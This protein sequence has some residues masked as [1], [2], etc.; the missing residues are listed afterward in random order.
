M[1]PP[2]LRT[3]RLLLREFRP[4]DVEPHAA[5]SRDAAAQRFLGGVKTPYEAFTNLATHAGHWSLRGYG[6]WV[7]ERLEDSAYL[8]RVGLFGPEGWPGVEVGWKLAPE[9]WGNGYATEAA[10]AAMGWAWTALGLPELISLIVPENAPS[11][12][13]ATRLGEVNTGPIETPFGTADRWRIRRPEGDAPWA[14][15]DATI[16]DAPRLAAL[17]RASMEG[18]RAFSPPGWEPPHTPDSELAG[19]LADPAPRCIL[20]EPGGVLAGH[21]AWRP[22]IGA[23]RGPQDPN[24]AY[25]GQIYVEPAWWGTELATKLMSFAFDGARATGFKNMTLITPAFQ[26]RARRF[27]ERLGFTTT[28][29]PTDDERFGMP[30]VEYAIAL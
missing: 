9:A 3:S 21:V 10:A 26:G 28:G 4:A 19:M 15:R 13:V 27:Y 30:T 11:Q 6:G 14:F 25:L 12:R 23:R 29:P 8:G 20:S 17:L 7:V 18:F 22:S 1:L 24:T 16:D 2:R 5:A